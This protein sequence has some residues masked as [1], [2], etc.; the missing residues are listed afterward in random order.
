M[1]Y[2]LGT[3]AAPAWVGTGTD[4][5]GNIALPDGVTVTATAEPLFSY[6][7]AAAPAA[8]YTITETQSRQ[9]LRVF[10]AASGRVTIGP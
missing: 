10:V 6:L 1:H 5:A 8:T 4:A 9:T 3:C 7:G 2:S